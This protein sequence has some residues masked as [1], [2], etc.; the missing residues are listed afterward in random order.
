MLWKIMKDKENNRNI[1]YGDLESI[2][3]EN[4]DEELIEV[5]FE[6][7]TA[8]ECAEIVSNILEDINRHNPLITPFDYLE[9]VKKIYG[10]EKIDEFMRLYVKTIYEKIKNY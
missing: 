4:C 3:E 1:F 6:E 7:W 5:P 9:M 8:Q 2:L 10:T